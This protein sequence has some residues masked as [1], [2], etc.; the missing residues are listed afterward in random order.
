VATVEAI[1]AHIAA[2]CAAIIAIVPEI[3]AVFATLFLA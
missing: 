3:A 2:C 1:T